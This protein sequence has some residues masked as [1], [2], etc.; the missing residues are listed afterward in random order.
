M[1]SMSIR[2]LYGA[3]MTVMLQSRQ[4]E[5]L[6]R[7]FVTD[8]S[9]TSYFMVIVMMCSWV[10]ETFDWPSRGVNNLAGV[11]AWLCGMAMLISA[12]SF[13]RR[14]WYAVSLC[15]SSAPGQNIS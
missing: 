15:L 14:R 12:T 5:L 4:S 1:D 13:I 8:S 7:L 10:E 11:I 6:L 3:S 2:R 9:F